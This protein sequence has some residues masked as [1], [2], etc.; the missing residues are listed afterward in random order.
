MLELVKLLADTLNNRGVAYCHWKSNFSLEKALSG[1]TDLDLLV[2]RRSL[3]QC[4]VILR[5]L[6]FRPATVKWGPEL[7]SGVY[8]Y[9]GFDRQADQHVHVHLFSRIITGE[10]FIKSHQLPIEEMLLGN[11]R[12]IQGIPVP[13]K[14]AELVL[15]I[16]RTF[17]KYGSFLDLIYLVRN[18]GN[19]EKELRWLQ[20][21]NDLSE[22]LQLLKQYC[23]VIDETLFVK[24]LD[25]LSP[26]GSVVKRSMLARRVRRRLRMYARYST[27]RRSLSYVHLLW[28]QGWRRI[29]GNRKNKLLRSG[30][31]MIAFIGPEAT[32]KSTLAAECERWL[33]GVFAVRH[34][35]AG[36]PPPS[37]L[38]QPVRWFL[39]LMR[40]SLPRL[41]STRIDGRNFSASTNPSESKTPSLVDLVYALRAVT[42]AWD[43]RKLLVK[44]RRAAT[45]G[46]IV[47]CDRYPS[48]VVGAMDSRRLHESPAKRGLVASIYNLLVRLEA[49]LYQQIP[50]PD[51]VLRLKVSI[52]TAKRRNRERIEADKESYLEA[53]HRHDGGWRMA[54]VKCLCDIDT[55]DC[56]AET[57]LSVKKIIWDAL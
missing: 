18:R 45:K 3:P 12:K 27:M 10:S 24:C 14:A 2:D 5:E 36:N 32:G 20:E 39:P 21:T 29:L 31:A 41:R 28:G 53:R 1:E 23:P 37:C 26:D 56:M 13:S 6:D 49:R 16:L 8:H 44:T 17:I 46:E 43:R 51:I 48:E 25:S 34:V 40:K 47:I 9:Y 22:P 52:E 15:F 38:T 7:P 42:L 19:I 35:H 50:P 11:T 4:I 54:G 55:E 33:G 30:G 57:F